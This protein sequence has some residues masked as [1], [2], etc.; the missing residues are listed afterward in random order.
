MRRTHLRGHTNI[1]KRLLIHAGGFNLL[2]AAS[3]APHKSA[4]RA[5]ITSGPTILYLRFTIQNRLS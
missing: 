4:N 5:Y 2:R 1:L 3:V